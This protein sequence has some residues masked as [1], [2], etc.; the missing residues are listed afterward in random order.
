MSRG[1]LVLAG[2]LLVTGTAGTS[3][4]KPTTKTEEEIRGLEQKM[5]EAYAKNDLQGYFSYYAPDFTQWLPDGRSDLDRYKRESQAYVSGGNSIQAAEVREMVLRVGPS[6]DAA[7]ASY[8][9][10]VKSKG[11]DGTITE[12]DSQETDVWFKRGGAWKVVALHYAPMKSG[13]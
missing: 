8:V 10:H 6:E 9:L 13:R 1:I 2:A 4:S 11:S 7:V 12:Q 3:V 5:N